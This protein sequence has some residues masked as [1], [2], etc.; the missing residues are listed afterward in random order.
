MLNTKATKK[1]FS[2]IF[3][4]NVNAFSP[5][6]NIPFYHPVLQCAGKYIF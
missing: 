4:E 1:T 3:K 2:R 5:C 6:I